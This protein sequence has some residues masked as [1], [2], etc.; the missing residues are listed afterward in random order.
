MD[1][2]AE[3]R[4]NVMGK[5]H[6]MYPLSF[7]INFFSLSIVLGSSLQHLFSGGVFFIY[8]FLHVRCISHTFSSM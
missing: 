6:F 1:Q 3:F 4:Q 5:T 7:L 8:L 2:S